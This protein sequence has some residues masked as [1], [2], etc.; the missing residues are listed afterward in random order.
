MRLDDYVWSRNPRGL[1]VY[2]I[3]QS[4]LDISR[5]TRI[6][7]G[8][9]KL[10]AA[11]LEYVDD[12]QHLLDL[13]ITPCVRLYLG[14]VGAVPFT[15]QLRSL[16]DAFARVGVRWFE[17][18]NEPN[19]GVEW[20]AGI[21]PDWRNTDSIIKPLMDNWL[22]FAEYVV[23]IGCYPGFIPLAESE[24][25]PYA[26]VPWMDTM[27][28]YLADNHFERY[29]RVLAN[30]LYCATHPYILNH[31]YQAAGSPTVAR[32]RGQVNAR[33]GGWY[34]EYPYDPL[35]QSRDPGR[36]VYG[37][38]ALTPRG[39]PVGLIA[40]G[41]MFNERSAEWFGSQ[42]VPVLGT[43]GGI[44]PFR[45]QVYQQDT[46]YPA[47]DE[48][49][50]AEGTVAMFEWIAR[51]APP[52]MFG[53]TLWKEDEYY[54]PSGGIVRAVDRLGD[55]PPVLKDVPAVEVMGTGLVVPTLPVPGPGPIHGAA[56]FHMVIL[57]PGLDSSWF[58]ET[59]RAY[60]DL[61]HPM[62]TTQTDLVDFIPGSQS[63][64][65][66]VIAPAEMVDTMRRAIA[67][68]YRYVYFDLV[69]ADSLVRVKE[70]FDGR[71]QLGLRFG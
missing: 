52:W 57:A 68:R 32:Q 40:M 54:L 20:P 21:D 36:T 34:F 24:D 29:Q 50:H 49:S 37:G 3:Y 23:S 19:L 59:A 60:W 39:D 5:Y 42:A 15:S 69:L 13:N 62:V 45:D 63:L 48:F 31:W 16:V 33:E 46:R 9:A 71:V 8:W 25:L 35:Q 53:V 30:G 10:M 64:A 14:H 61:F 1:H 26:A 11:G 65:V 66:T 4:P 55:T 56:D 2:S 51:Q 44:F 67:E 58:F 38:T 27:L 41:R 18:Y 22:L 7:A 6:H 70:V 12:A 17:F 43:E 28:R 47:Y